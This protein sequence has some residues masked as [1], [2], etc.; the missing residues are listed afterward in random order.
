MLGP[1]IY[2]AQRALDRMRK[3]FGIPDNS[4]TPP[5]NDTSADKETKVCRYSKCETK[6][7]HNNACCC[8]KHYKLWRAEQKRS[9]S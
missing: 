9:K 3:R 7:N 4:H 8:A 6:H 5:I 2:E 1:Y